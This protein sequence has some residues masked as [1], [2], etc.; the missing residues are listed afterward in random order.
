MAKATPKQ[1]PLILPKPYQA[2]GGVDNTLGQTVEKKYARIELL[3]PTEDKLKA[4]VHNVED[5]TKNTP[6][7]ASTVN[8]VYTLIN[9]VFAGQGAGPDG[10]A[11]WA[12][13]NA[14]A[15][16]RY[17]GAEFKKYRILLV[18]SGRSGASKYVAS[19]SD[20]VQI[21]KLRANIIDTSLDQFGAAKVQSRGTKE[22]EEDAPK[23]TF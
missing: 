13:E 15:V 9:S 5:A 19:I 18:P 23:I 21:A 16:Y 12:T 10:S 20:L 11:C 8:F 3:E 17:W 14:Q 7:G 1:V 6:L 4:L 22:I 2:N